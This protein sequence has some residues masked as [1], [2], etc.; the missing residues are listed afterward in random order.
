MPHHRSPRQKP[1]SSLTVAAGASQVLSPAQME[2]NKRM[3]S[4]ECAQKALEKERARLDKMVNICYQE[5]MPLAAELNLA[6]F[7]LIF[8]TDHGRRTTKLTPRRNRWLADLIS[9][10][11]TDCLADGAGLNEEQIT[12]LEDLIEELGPCLQDQEEDAYAKE[13]F[14]DFT[15]M[16]KSA[17][18]AMDLDLSDLDIHGDPA[19]FEREIHRRLQAVSDEMERKQAAGEL[20]P[21]PAKRKRKP[22]KA[23]VERER[24]QSRHRHRRE[25]PHLLVD[26]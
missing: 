16:L 15:S 6:G 3:K 1:A 22:T 26:P 21:Q 17:A 23:A 19:E 10:K 14:E 12:R 2:F 4:L 24:R 9:G 18:G 11:A 5:L 20:P 8:T 7:D 13:E 25:T